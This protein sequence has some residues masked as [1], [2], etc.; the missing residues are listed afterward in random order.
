MLNDLLL[1]WSNRPAISLALWLV[2]L[3]TVLY[4]ARDP[5]HQ[6]IKSTGRA[7]Y[8]FMRSAARAIAQIEQRAIHRN[9]EIILS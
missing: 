8:R 5:A 4:L 3:V 9:K 1:L 6:L 7:I 2:V